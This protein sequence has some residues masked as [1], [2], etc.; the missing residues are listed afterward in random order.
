MDQENKNRIIV[1]AVLG[2]VMVGNLRKD[3]T[4][5]DSAINRSQDFLYAC[6]DYLKHHGNQILSVDGKPKYKLSLTEIK[7][8][9]E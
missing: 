8:G 1:T 6:I 4:I 7:E 2:E 9:E 5:S 3:G